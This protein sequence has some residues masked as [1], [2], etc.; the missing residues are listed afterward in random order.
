MANVHTAIACMHV[1]VCAYVPCEYRVRFDICHCVVL[2]IHFLPPSH[3]EFD[4]IMYAHVCK[5]V[6]MRFR[7]Y[8]SRSL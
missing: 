8:S 1:S 7:I 3:T 2:R 4:F 5:C 6:C